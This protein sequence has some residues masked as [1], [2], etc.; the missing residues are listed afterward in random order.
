MD[1]VYYPLNTLKRW[2]NE[3]HFKNTISK[4][5]FKSVDGFINIQITINHCFDC[6]LLSIRLF[7]SIFLRIE[8]GCV[9][10]DS[11]ILLNYFLQL[12]YFLSDAHFHFIYLFIQFISSFSPYLCCCFVLWIPKQKISVSLSLHLIIH[13]I[14]TF[15]IGFN[16][17]LTHRVQR[18]I[19]LRKK[20]R[21]KQTNK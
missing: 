14:F 10:R 6:I 13:F 15:E 12:C 3:N 16:K 21:Q 1:W 2:W 18:N 19:I 5:S 8:S 4:V 11:Y 17:L 9:D 7:F 20:Q